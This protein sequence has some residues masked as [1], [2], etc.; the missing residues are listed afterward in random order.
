MIDKNDISIL[1]PVFDD[2]ASLKL[3]LK[4]IEKLSDYIFQIII[5]DDGSR[6]HSPKY[7]DFYDSLLTIKIVKLKENNGHQ[8]AI[9]FGL[10]YIASHF[11]SST[12]IV[13]D[14]D[15]ED[16]AYVIPIL[17]SSL[18]EEISVVFNGRI[19]RHRSFIN[20]IFYLAFWCIARI[21]TGESISVGN[22]SALTSNAVKKL[23]KIKQAPIHFAA[24]I[25]ASSLEYS[26]IKIERNDRYLSDS[27]MSFI[28]LIELAFR[29]ISVFKTKVF[30]RL[31][32]ISLPGLIL[33]VDLLFFQ[34]FS[35][36]LMAYSSNKFILFFL[37]LQIPILIITFI[38]FVLIVLSLNNN[39]RILKKISFSNSD[40]TSPN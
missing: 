14:A 36:T 38:L 35:N 32:A 3:L 37:Y 30:F 40:E 39:K 29:A 7:E 20:K 28:G 23:L 27:K 8:V 9:Y 22:F 21:L 11:P 10:R 4:D 2:T 1:L 34:Y 13:M 12:V 17:L 25:I 18:N 16:P 26:I 33:L 19:K 31:F 15:G 24:A 5:I 6:L